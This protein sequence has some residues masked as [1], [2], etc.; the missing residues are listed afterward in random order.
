MG[1]VY[2][3]FDEKLARRV[4]LKVIHRLD[5]A[6]RT[7][8]LRE[9]QTLSQLDHPNIC[10]IYDCIEEDEGDILVLELI[11]G[12]TL[13]A[14]MS[15]GLARADKLRIA[16][17]ISD[18]LVTAHRA[19]IIHRDLK[20]DNVM[21]T[22]AGQVK[23]LDF[24]LARWVD[25]AEP[26]AWPEHEPQ[27][28]LAGDE[29]DDGEAS[30]TAVLPMR[31]NHSPQR[32]ESATLVGTAVGTPL[33]MS[34]EQARG[35]SL[36]T[37]SDMY[38]FGLLLQ[39]LFSGE[40]PYS[41]GDTLEEVLEKASRGESLPPR[42]VERD[43][44][45]LVQRLKALAPSDRP[46]AVEALR[47]LRIIAEKPKRIA[48]RV[49][50]AALALAAI[51]GTWKYTVDLRRE[52]AAAIAAET[53]ARQRRADADHLISFMLG[54]LRKKL[55]PVGKLDILDDVAA[56]ALTVL[57]STDRERMTA[58]E[59][60]R[61]ATALDQLGEVRISQGK[62]AD[63]LQAFQKARVLAEAAAVRA[64]GDAEAQLTYATS[65]FWIG[66]AL[67][68][69]GD[70]PEALAHITVYRDI[71]STL[72]RR[73]PKN[74][75]Y[76][77]EAAYGSSGVGT[78]REAQ[79]Q[80]AEALDDYRATRALKAARVA[81]APEDLDRQADLAVTLDKIGGVLLRLGDLSSARETF[82]SE[83]A[84]LDTLTA[85]Q[86]NNMTW[87]RRLGVSYSYLARSC[88]ISGDP[89]QAL[90][91]ARKQLDLAVDL[92]NRD[93]TN[94]DR[95]RE[96][97]AARGQLGRLLRLQGQPAD[98]LREIEVSDRTLRAM[99]EKEPQRKDWHRDLALCEVNRGWTLL[100]L[101]RGGEAEAAVA[102]ATVELQK[103]ASDAAGRRAGAEAL[104]IRGEAAKA[105]GDVAAARQ[106][107]SE[108][109]G[110]LAAVAAKDSDPVTLALYAGA[111][112]RLG[113]DAEAAPILTKL[114]R[115]GYG[116]PDLMTLRKRFAKST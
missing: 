23:V 41:A 63:A 55:E 7:R 58:G 40:K 87:K 18:V 2:E 110:A 99:V 50:A 14:A 74:D 45:L 30:S 76:Q 19:G 91:F 10:R 33:Y 77:I 102:A 56:R 104:L 95:L 83:R 32:A 6:S 89:G 54:D 98:A 85:K 20:P 112:L 88:E 72:A 97:A 31:R 49:A 5:S 61:T 93:P 79:G 12:R 73:H 103:A 11:E 44:R 1:A 3:G 84:I 38:S 75:K 53:D 101:R 82:A 62:L 113:R 81:A 70:L 36:T 48:Q 15:A 52:R 51:T 27:A 37:A 25:A 94:A 71:A 67:R 115:I 107:W 17:A 39:V 34:P 105:R 13:Q 35:E 109:A 108:A 96:V 21:L 66:N 9:A 100:A 64:P 86:P 90:D 8:F 80:L 92:S 65:R 59:L 69:R 57:S 114:D 24:G 28:N 68:L 46:T 22:V 78:I 29:S 42:G 16:R 4:A 43:I 111:L 26:S 60:Q 116:H 47:R 106:T